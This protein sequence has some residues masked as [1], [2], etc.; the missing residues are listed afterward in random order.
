MIS[1]FK[2]SIDNILY[3]RLSSPLFGAFLFSWCV[4]NWKI[5]YLTIFIDSKLVGNKIDYIITNYSET[6]HLIYYPILSTIFLIFIYPLIAT[7]TFWVSL[8]FE[9]LKVSLRNNVQNKQVLSIEQSILLREEVSNQ[10]EK[11]DRLLTKKNEEIEALKSETDNYKKQL[12][13]LNENIS[14]L[15]IETKENIYLQEFELLKSNEL[16]FKEFEKIAPKALKELTMFSETS[17]INRKLFDYFL[18]NDIIEKTGRNGVYKFT[19]KGK[20][21]NKLVMNSKLF[22]NNHA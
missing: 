13:A 2:K 1:D 12:L 22:E 3:D 4:W 14:E 20:Y 7:G 5:I 15:P 19:N 6:S 10:D 16:L 18:T 11:F 21:F 9:N 17:T 8:K